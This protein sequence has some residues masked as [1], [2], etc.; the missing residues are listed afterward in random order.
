[1]LFIILIFLAA[2]SA[3]LIISRRDKPALLMGG[4]CASLIILLIGIIIYTAKTGGLSQPQKIFLFLSPS[5]QRR[6]MFLIFPLNKLGYTIAIGRYLFPL[7][8]LLAACEYSMVH[9][10]R[11]LRNWHWVLCLC[12]AAS[13]ILYYPDVFHKVV[14]NRFML[15]R[16]LMTAMVIWIVLYLAAAMTLLFYE[17]NSISMPYYRRQFRCI[18]ISLIC[19][20]LLYC[21][22]GFQDPIQV[23]QLYTTEYMWFNGMSYAN[24]SLSMGEWLL[25]TVIMVLLV[26]L[27]FWNLRSYSKFSQ[28]NAEDISMKRKFDTA[29]M[30]ASVFIHSIK[31]QL[32]AARV[33]HTKITHELENPAADMEK[34]R[35]YAARLEELNSN[36]LER[37]EELYRSVKSNTISLTPIPAADIVEL[38]I[39]RFRLKY[40]DAKVD[41]TLETEAPVLA[42]SVHLAEALYNLLAN[43]EDAVAATGRVDGRVAFIVHDERLYIVFEVRDNGGGISKQEQKKIFDPFYT[44]KNTSCNWGMGLYYVRQILKSHLG[45]LRVESIQGKGASFFALLPRYMPR[46][47]GRASGRICTQPKGAGYDSHPDCRGF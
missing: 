27:G 32:L 16:Y 40:P 8:L 42:D 24:P 25:L 45:S 37:M 44:S 9:A 36:M 14:R 4:L 17:Y 12:P 38:A 6:L 5:I 3:A 13:L 43:A 30:G 11:R 23:Y 31:N 18:V 33:A 34:L 7:F 47:R 46:E 21:L 15:Q 1:M 41:V 35:D 39:A 29:S 10:V 20:T 2:G 22:Y 28:D 19:I 26:V